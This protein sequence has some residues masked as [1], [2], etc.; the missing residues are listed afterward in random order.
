MLF[1]KVGKENHKDEKLSFLEKTMIRAAV[2]LV[3]VILWKFKK[4]KTYGDIAILGKLIEKNLDD[5]EAKYGE[6]GPISKIENE[7]EVKEFVEDL[8]RLENEIKEKY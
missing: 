7:N 2:P 1:D 8:E 5:M 3:K 4:A 6:N